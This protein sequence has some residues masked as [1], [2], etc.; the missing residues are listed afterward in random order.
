MTVEEADLLDPRVERSRRV[1]LA[2][3]LEVLGEEGYGGLTIEAVAARA[4]VGK[5]TIYRHWDG[6]LAL[7]E[8]AFR[9]LRMVENPPTGGS[10]RDRVVSMLS[11]VAAKMASSAWSSCMP[12]LID[13]AE[14]DDQVREVHRSLFCD[15]R[16][17]LV[18]L[19]TAGVASGELPADVDLDLLAETL[20][21]P[22]IVHRLLLHDP[23]DP[24]RVP[25]LVDLVLPR[26][27]H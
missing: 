5:S 22:L 23:L 24:R 25:A 1:V 3:A 10:V 21:G 18:E 2:A 9:T 19:L 14:R 20:I 12:A 7:V 4:G 17:V 26:T 6:K 16:A 15:R 11:Q 13:A 27:S 8:D